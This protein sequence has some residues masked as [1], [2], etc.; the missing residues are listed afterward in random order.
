MCLTCRRAGS[1]RRPHSPSLLVTAVDRAGHTHGKAF[2]D[3]VRNLAGDVEH[4]PTWWSGR[5]PSRTSSTCST[6]ARRRRGGRPVRRR[7]LGRRRR[8]GRV[9]STGPRCRS[10]SAG[11]TG[12]SR[13]TRCRALRGSRPACSARCSRTQLRPHGSRCGTSRSRSSSRRSAAG[14]RRAPGGHYATLYTHID[15]L[16]ES[17]RVVT[18]GGRERVPPAAGVGRRAVARPPVPRLR[19]HARHHHRGVDAGAGPAA[20]AALGHASPSSTSPRPSRPRARSRSPGSVPG[21]LPAARRRRGDPQCRRDRRHRRPARARLRVGRP[22]GRA[23]I[24]AGASRSA[25]TTAATSPPASASPDHGDD[26]P[27]AGRRGRRPGAARSSDALPA[28]RAG[29]T[30]MIVETF[31]TACT[32]DRFDEL[33]A[34]V[35]AAATDA[36]RPDLRRPAWV[37]CR[38]THVYPDG[39]APYFSDL[40]PGRCGQRASRSGTRS[41]RRRPRRSSRTAAPSPTTTRSAATTGP[42]TTSSAPTCSPPRSRAAKQALDPAGVLNPGVLLDAGDPALPLRG[43]LALVWSVIGDHTTRK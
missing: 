13:S 7:V 19:G 39:P 31:E 28:R 29:A 35:T 12:C 23:W 14:S 16:V 34:A 40:A 10:T 24:G 3:V 1:L 8:R 27:A 33:H 2:R 9:E 15:D 41:R 36:R 17:M 26:A 25:A 43:H 6:G 11:S 22:P 38:F 5:A 21:Q 37:T 18:P 32:W 4:F 42:G 30:A 20:L